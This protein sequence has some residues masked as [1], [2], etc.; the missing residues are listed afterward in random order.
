MRHT[1]I[2]QMAYVYI[3][4]SSTRVTKSYPS[5]LGTTQLSSCVITKHWTKFLTHQTGNY[6]VTC[7]VS[8]P[9]GM[10]LVVLS[11]HSSIRNQRHFIHVELTA[12]TRKIVFIERC[13]PSQLLL[14]CYVLVR[15]IYAYDMYERN[16]KKN[17]PHSRTDGN[18]WRYKYLKREPMWMMPLKKEKLK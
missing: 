18:P 16:K 3:H 4:A 12:G 17:T 11:H 1:D 2:V 8:K 15:C 9:S 6:P 14:H 13:Q 5:A 10:T 7:F